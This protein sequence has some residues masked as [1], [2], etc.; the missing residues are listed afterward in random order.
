MKLID[1]VFVRKELKALDMIKSTG[2]DGIPAKLLKA[3]V[4]STGRALTHIFNRT[5]VLGTIPSE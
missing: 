3:S 5:V 4:A 1:V 2:I